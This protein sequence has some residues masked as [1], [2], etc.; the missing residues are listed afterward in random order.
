MDYDDS[1][2]NIS[3][4]EMNYDDLKQRKGTIDNYYD[5]YGNWWLVFVYVE[6]T[7]ETDDNI[8]TVFNVLDFK[9]AS[10]DSEGEL[11]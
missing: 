3:I 1:F 10:E 11:K 5:Q 9:P 2:E 4:E 6:K 7:E 8:H